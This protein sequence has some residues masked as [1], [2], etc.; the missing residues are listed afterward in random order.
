MVDEQTKVRNSN[1][2]ILQVCRKINQ[3]AEAI[4]HRTTLYIFGS[5]DA[6]TRM[7]N[8]L[9][10][11]F[12]YH[13]RHV[14]LDI[15]LPS[16]GHID[17]RGFCHLTLS[18]WGTALRLLY[19]RRGRALKRLVVILRGPTYADNIPPFQRRCIDPWQFDYTSIRDAVVKLIR[20]KRVEISDDIVKL[21]S[22]SRGRPCQFFARVWHV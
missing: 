7:A 18:Q 4:L 10:F 12:F 8:R 13:L 1:C 20:A 9:P 5:P 19:R 22:L 3:E 11:A 2:Q 14:K 15:W 16:H 21:D 6:I 17:Y